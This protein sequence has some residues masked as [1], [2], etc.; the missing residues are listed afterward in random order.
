MNY[1]NYKNF[2]EVTLIN[3]GKIALRYFR[4]KPKSSSKL[5]GSIVTIADENIEKFITIQISKFFPEHS[6]YGEEFSSDNSKLQDEFCWVIDPIDG[7]SSF[8][9]GRP[10]WGI[11]LALMHKGKPV[12]GAIYN[13]FTE[14]LWLGIKGQKNYKSYYNNKMIS[15]KKDNKNS[16]QTNIIAT[17]SPDLLDKKGRFLFDDLTK[18]FSAK[19][20]YGGDCYNYGLLAN[21]YIKAIYEQ[22]LKPYDY[23]PLLPILWGVNAKITDENGKEITN[24]QKPSSLICVL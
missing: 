5:D 24:Y 20:I 7:T 16:N 17:T 12:I 6:I 23:L 8:A 13:P 15:V 19:K 4:N 1:I 21:G 11:M 2:V 18:K 3:A 22:V 14:D 10:M 9:S